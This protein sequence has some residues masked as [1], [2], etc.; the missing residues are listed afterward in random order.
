MNK[1]AIVKKSKIEDNAYKYLFSIL[2][3]F[4]GFTLII[5][6]I[7]GS[8]IP[9]PLIPFFLL[10][11]SGLALIGLK[12]ETVNKIRKRMNEFSKKFVGK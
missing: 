10:T 4:L 1:N 9:I 5:L 7:L 2:K 6:G 8:L 12:P 11:L 3:K